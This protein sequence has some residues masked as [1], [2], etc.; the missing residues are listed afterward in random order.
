MINLRKG[1]NS[2]K[3]YL[4]PTAA[5]KYHYDRLAEVS[6]SGLIDTDSNIR[7]DDILV[8]NA[9]TSTSYLTI[10]SNEESIVGSTECHCVEPNSKKCENYTPLSTGPRAKTPTASSDG[11]EC[12]N[13]P[14]IISG[15]TECK[16]P[17]LSSTS[18]VQY[19]SPHSPLCGEAADCN[20]FT[21]SGYANSN[22]SSGQAASVHTNQLFVCLDCNKKFKHYASLYK[23]SAHVHKNTLK[24]RGSI[25]CMEHDCLF[26]CA[27]LNVLQEHLVNVHNIDFKEETRRFDSEKGNFSCHACCY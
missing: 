1:S 19:K 6:K 23:H 10:P 4:E 12:E 27:R 5:E 7:Y 18:E 13:P 25:K 15:D 14:I 16:T 22:D 21:L 9:Q 20:S 24:K 2:T 17:P 3:K 11:S 8:I 26:T